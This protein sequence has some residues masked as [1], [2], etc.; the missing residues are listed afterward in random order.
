[1]IK[2][3][4]EALAES[5]AKYL[6]VDNKKVSVDSLMVSS[7]CKKLNRIELIYSVNSRL[8]KD[9][10]NIAPNLIAEEL[11]PYLEKGHKNDTIYRTRDLQVDSKLL[12]KQSKLL[13]DISLK[14]GDIVTSTEEF[15]L[16]KDLL[17][18]KLHTMMPII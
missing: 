17:K 18:N 8:I 6:D 15:Q 11:K 2:A 5:I 1:M 7:S 13:Y 12:I 14:A 16:L 10:N 4:V 9:I 3:E